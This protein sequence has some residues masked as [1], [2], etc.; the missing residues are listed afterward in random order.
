MI[1][2]CADSNS[3]VLLVTDAKIGRE[4]NIEAGL[5]DRG[6]DQDAQRKDHS[7]LLDLADRRWNRRAAIHYQVPEVGHAL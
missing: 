4:Q 2:S 6:S 3:Q 1:K 5:R 7:V